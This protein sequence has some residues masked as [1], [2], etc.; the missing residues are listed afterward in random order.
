MAKQL[1]RL[2]LKAFLT[3]DALPFLRLLEAKFPG[4]IDTDLIA[5]LEHCVSNNL[6]L[7]AL[8]EKLNYAN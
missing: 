6:S 7:K 5:H 3:D 2:D 8:L 1:D 4:N